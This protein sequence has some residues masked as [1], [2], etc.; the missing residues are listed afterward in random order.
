MKSLDEIKKR[1]DLQNLWTIAY[2]YDQRQSAFQ[3]LKRFY[4]S[5]YIHTPR[6]KV[7]LADFLRSQEAAWK[8]RNLLGETHS[9]H[10]L[11]KCLALDDVDD[12]AGLRAEKQDA[13]R[14]NHAS[15]GDDLAIARREEWDGSEQTRWLADIVDR[16]ATCRTFKCREIQYWNHPDLPAHLRVPGYYVCYQASDHYGFP[17]YVMISRS[18]TNECIELEQIVRELRSPEVIFPFSAFGEYY[19][20]RSVKRG[21][22]TYSTIKFG[23]RWYMISVCGMLRPFH[24]LIRGEGAVMGPLEPE[25]R[26]WLKQSNDNRSSSG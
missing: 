1:A 25:F 14:Q 12:P 4:R 7:L 3:T 16:L 11:D 8:N 18:D 23:N 22:G 24:T 15:H 10:F 5:G 19:A 2:F 21:P 20:K 6:K 9:L 17:L 26:N 13:H